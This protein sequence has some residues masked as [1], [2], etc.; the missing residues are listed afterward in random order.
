MRV[1]VDIDGICE[2]TQREKMMMGMKSKMG[3]R[4]LE[5]FI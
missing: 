1:P 5:A 2:V 3:D 4:E